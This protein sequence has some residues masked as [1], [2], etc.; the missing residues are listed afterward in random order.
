MWDK[1]FKPRQSKTIKPNS[2]SQKQK[3]LV[4]NGTLSHW[5]IPYKGERGMRSFQCGTKNSS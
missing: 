2:Q 1:E 3:F 5:L 4:T